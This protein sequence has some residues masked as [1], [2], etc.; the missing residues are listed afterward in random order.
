MSAAPEIAEAIRQLNQWVC[1]ELELTALCP[2]AKASLA[3]A[4]DMQWAWAQRISR[5]ED[6]DIKGSGDVA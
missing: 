5:L 3:V 6:E 1:L 4:K 2:E